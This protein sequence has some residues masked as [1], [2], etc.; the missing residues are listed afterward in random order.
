MPSE[1]LQTAFAGLERRA[2]LELEALDF[3]FRFF[4]Q[5]VGVAEFHRRKGESQVT[6]PPAE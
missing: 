5:R 6:A 4:L 2:E 1:G 3:V